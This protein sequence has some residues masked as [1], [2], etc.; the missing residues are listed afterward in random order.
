MV[1]CYIYHNLYFEVSSW[2]M[3]AANVLHLQQLKVAGTAV[4]DGWNSCIVMCFQGG[5]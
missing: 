1:K 5:K 3:A 4:C 2:F